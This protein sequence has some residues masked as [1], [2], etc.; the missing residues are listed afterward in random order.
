M[1]VV[2]LAG[3]LGARLREET[4]F[5]PKPMVE[6][7][8]KPILWHLMKIY[9]S[10]GFKDFVICA[11]Y[12]NE[13]IK[14]YF[15]NYKSI[16][17]DFTVNLKSGAITI[18]TNENDLDWN[19]TVVDT[20]GDTQTGGRLKRIRSY[21]G[22]EKFMA[23]YGDGLANIDIKSLIHAHDLNHHDYEI[24][25]TLTAI[26]SKSRFGEIEWSETDEDSGFITSFEEKSKTSWINGGFFVFEPEIFD[27]IS[28]DSEPLEAGLLSTLTK[29]HKLGLYKHDQ[30]WA[31]MDD[32]KETLALN[33]LWNTGK[34]PWKL[35]S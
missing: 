15:L 18:H 27:L 13:V 7:G 16:E 32:Y 1:K 21:I 29:M 22:N 6:I 23:T 25:A 4:E 10:Q 5:K 8:G 26:L 12:K 35:W 9:A 3:G 30:F 11:G 2:I 19:V 20:G 17:N 31:S 24:H 14:N 34:A 28:G 33:A